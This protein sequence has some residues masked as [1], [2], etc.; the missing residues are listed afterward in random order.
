ML[1]VGLAFDLALEVKKT[2]AT[3]GA[4]M[5]IEQLF[6]SFEQLD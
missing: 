4:G 2:K 5:V 6:D 3:P 1:I